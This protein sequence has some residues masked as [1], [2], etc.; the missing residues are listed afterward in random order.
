MELFRGDTFSKT[1]VFENYTLTE[2]DIVK[3]GLKGTLYDDEYTLFTEI[4][5]ER[6]CTEIVFAFDGTN[7]LEIG[8]Y[9]FEIELTY[10][11]G[12]V[13]TVYQAPLTVRGDVI[14][15]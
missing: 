4:P 2:G 7:N 5:I 3:V 11:N 8:E 1:I 10:N 12:K 6:S 13:E 15:D 14:R 9:I